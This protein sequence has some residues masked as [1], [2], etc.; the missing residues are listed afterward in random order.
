[1]EE[2]ERPDGISRRRILKRIGAGA[3][4]AWAAPVLTSIRMPAFAQSTSGLCTANW[5]CG[6]T[7]V[8][9]GGTPGESPCDNG[10]P[11]VCVCDLTVEGTSFCWNNFC[12]VGATICT[13]SD[14]CGGGSA[15]VTSCCGQRCA[16]PCGV[17]GQ[18]GT[19]GGPSGAHQ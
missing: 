19:A 11:P 18:A 5:N 2:I 14:D 15:C 3:A 9:C 6:D 17:T 8:G 12:C 16:P 4:I 10:S 7:I 13:T 1:M